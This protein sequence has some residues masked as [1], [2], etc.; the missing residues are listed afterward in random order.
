VILIH[1]LLTKFPEHN[2]SARIRYTHYTKT[3]ADG[4]NN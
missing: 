1:V 2:P 3:R 4:I